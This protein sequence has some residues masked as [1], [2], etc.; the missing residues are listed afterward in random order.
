M[1]RLLTLGLTEML[2][3]RRAIRLLGCL[4]LAEHQDLEEQQQT[5]L[6]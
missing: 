5:Q 3:L 6:V 4:R 2:T 1:E